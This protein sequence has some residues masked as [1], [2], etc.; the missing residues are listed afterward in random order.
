MSI[1]IQRQWETLRKIP[2]YPSKISPP[3]LRE[4]LLAEGYDITL[5]SVQR[6]LEALSEHFP[7]SRDDFRPSG[8]FWMKGA[9]PAEIPGMD[10]H[11]A[12]TF[13]LVEQQLKDQLPQTT[14]KAL[15]G[16][17]K[18]ARGVLAKLRDEGLP[19]WAD[20]VRVIPRGQSQLAPKVDEAVLSAVY[21]ALLQ[22]KCLR[23]RYKNRAGKVSDG[24]VSP[25]GLVYRD[26][27]PILIC[28]WVKYPDDIRQ[29][30]LH[31]FISAENI[32][33]KRKRP[34]GFSLSA[35]IDEGMMGFPLNKKPIQL[36]ARFAEGA[37]PNVLEAPLTADQ[38]T[39]T[40][41]DGSVTVKARLVDTRVLRAWLLS[42]GPMVE[43]LA[44]KRLRVEMAE[45]LKRAAALYR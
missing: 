6:D 24:E 21:E 28:T 10:P 32:D 11:L 39:T 40:N 36:V 34:K 45:D 17:F 29:L 4:K 23:I 41:E 19:A 27:M 22:E 38:S 3:K 8:W 13:R 15:A 18:A 2:R 12:I 16:H 44:P 5:R 20:K 26:A 9:E 33:K 14:L 7:I 1:T 35:Y 42:F 30:A 43:V 25:I 31:R 37:A